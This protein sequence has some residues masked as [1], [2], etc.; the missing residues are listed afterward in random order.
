[1]IVKQNAE[2][3][4]YNGGKNGE[5]EEK[6]SDANSDK[7]GAGVGIDAL[8]AAVSS[9]GDLP[10]EWRQALAGLS[11][12]ERLKLLGLDPKEY[13]VQ[14]QP[15]GSKKRKGRRDQQQQQ[16][17]SSSSS[18]SATAAAASGT[19]ARRSTTLLPSLMKKSDI[20]KKTLPSEAVRAAALKEGLRVLLKRKGPKTRAP[21]PPAKEGRRETAVEVSDKEPNYNPP[22]DGQFSSSEPDETAPLHLTF[23]R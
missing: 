15:T 4:L 18:S 23:V 12:V 8:L 7:G 5:E 11:T 1:M 3:D 21:S 14:K 13:R 16:T 20:G 19:Q 2:L 22:N 6:Q 9:N 10:L 17:L